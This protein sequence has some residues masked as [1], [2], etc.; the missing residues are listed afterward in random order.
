MN[1]YGRKTLRDDFQ[2]IPKKKKKKKKEPF[3]G[4]KR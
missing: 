3:Y 2:T 1:S 4:T